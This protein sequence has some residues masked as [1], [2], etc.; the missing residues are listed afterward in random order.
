MFK[1]SGKCFK[2]KRP[3]VALPL[4]TTSEEAVLCYDHETNLPMPRDAVYFDGDDGQV[5]RYCDKQRSGKPLCVR[6][7]TAIEVLMS[8]SCTSGGPV[9]DMIRSVR[10]SAA[11]PH[12]YET[13]LKPIYESAQRVAK[14]VS[15]LFVDELKSLDRELMM[16]IMVGDGV[17]LLLLSRACAQMLTS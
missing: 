4:D 17:R 11:S 14:R 16:L 9:S 12:V 15:E 6:V 8:E 13:A 5:W 1:C 3:S 7:S 10:P 2:S